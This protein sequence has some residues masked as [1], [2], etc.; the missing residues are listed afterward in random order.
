[1]DLRE[2]G[3]DAGDLVDLTQDGNQCN[4]GICRIGNE[5]PGSLNLTFSSLQKKL[6]VFISLIL[7]VKSL[8]FKWKIGTL[9]YIYLSLFLTFLLTFF[10]A[11][12]L[13]FSLS[14]SHTLSPAH[15]SR[16]NECS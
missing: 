11:F 14:L 15:Y 7:D 1:M 16:N 2:V 10:L 8:L 6:E 13:S 4:S 12:F 9:L 3:C 5:T